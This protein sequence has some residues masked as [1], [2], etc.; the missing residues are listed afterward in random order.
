MVT[1]PV[2]PHYVDPI[3]DP[4]ATPLYSQI[5]M[6][7]MRYRHRVVPYG[8]WRVCATCARPRQSKTK[9]PV[10]ISLSLT[11]RTRW[12]HTPLKKYEFVSWDFEIPNWMEKSSSLVPNHQPN[13]HIGSM[14][15]ICC[16]PMCN[17]YSYIYIWVNYNN[18]L[19]S[20]KAN[21]GNDFAY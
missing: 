14:I 3:I 10:A 11:H 17:S 16:K 7:E 18:S 8:S 13:N 21:K 15:F 12:L 6:E 9:V 20:I 1:D 4:I 5:Q 2:C 19:T